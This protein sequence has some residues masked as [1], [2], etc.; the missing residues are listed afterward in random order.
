[1]KNTYFKNKKP[2]ICVIG[3]GIVGSA[4]GKAFIAKGLDVSFLGVDREKIEEFKKNG[5]KAYVHEDFYNGNYDFD[6]SIFTVPTPTINGKIDLSYLY[7]ASLDLGKRLAHRDNYHLV[8]VKSTVVPGTSENLVAKTLEK[9]SEKKLGKDFGLC[10]NPE[11]LREE[12]AYQDTIEPWIIVIGEYDKKSGDILNDVYLKFDAP[13][14]RTSIKEAEIQKYVHNLFNATKITFF[15]EIREIGH[16]LGLDM[17][18]IFKL[19][20]ISSEGMWNPK[21]GIRNKGPFSGSCLPKDTQAF[22]SWTIE[23]GFS[24]EL[25]KTTIDVNESLKDRIKIHRHKASFKVS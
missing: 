22:L 8:V 17:E 21:Y 20:A 12:T 24:A 14:Y 19:T 3:P 5:Y 7:N 23:N 16:K 4:T 10:M 9:Y 25:L 13:V 1:M 15:N 11:Y 2:K 6:I 18:R